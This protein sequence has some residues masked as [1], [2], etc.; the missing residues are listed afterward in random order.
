MGY[1]ANCGFPWTAKCGLRPNWNPPGVRGVLSTVH[2]LRAARRWTI[3]WVAVADPHALATQLDTL[4]PIRR[5]LESAVL[6]AS[7][8]RAN[9]IA[10]ARLLEPVDHLAF[11]RMASEA[12]ALESRS[13]VAVSNVAVSAPGSPL[14][15]ALA[16]ALMGSGVRYVVRSSTGHAPLE[17]LEALDGSRVLLISLPPE[18]DPHSLGLAASRD[19]MAR[20][21]E[22]WLLAQPHPFPL[23]PAV[24]TNDG[25]PEASAV[26]LDREPWEDGAAV[27]NAVQEWNTRFAYPRIVRGIPDALFTTLSRA[28]DT[29]IPVARPAPLRGSPV[30]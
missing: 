16:L 4:P 17:W 24:G 21:I 13:G 18:S 3:Y 28:P 12:R 20:Q 14:P 26:V 7:G 15:R 22:R 23:P 2:R 30:M 25:T 8:V 10:Q 1:T 6:N 29:H 27:Y 19:E 9:P 5:A 11:I